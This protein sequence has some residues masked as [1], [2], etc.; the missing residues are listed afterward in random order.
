MADVLAPL[1]QLTGV[2][3]DVT[4][5]RAAVDRALR[6]P[7]LGGPRGPGAAGGGRGWAGGRAAR[8]GRRH[9]GAA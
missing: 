2:R 1:L 8:G 3:D 7:A 4:A 6:H 9:P 5:A